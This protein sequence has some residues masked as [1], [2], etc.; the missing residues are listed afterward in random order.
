[1][2]IDQTWGMMCCVEVGAPR[3]H[4]GRCVHQLRSAVNLQAVVLYRH[5]DHR[6]QPH[7]WHHRRHFL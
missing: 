4:A 7:P 5:H 3:G 6:P 1:M 2:I